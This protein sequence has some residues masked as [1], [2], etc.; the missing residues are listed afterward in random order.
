MPY[1]ERIE[2]TPSE[3]EVGV[4]KWNYELSCRIYP[5]NYVCKGVVWRSDNPDIVEVN[6]NSG[7]LRGVSVGTAIVTAEIS[8]GWGNYYYGSCT[9]EVTQNGPGQNPESDYPGILVESINLYPESMV[10][11]EGDCFQI[12]AG[13]FPTNATYPTLEWGSDNED[14]AIVDQDGWVEARSGGTVCIWARATDGSDVE[15]YCEVR[16]YSNDV[17]QRSVC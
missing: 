11:H 1:I 8:D 13:V 12:S 3:I 15:S 9:V 6:E 16:V 2:V 10:M 14:I 7:Y 17:P 4:N 5:G